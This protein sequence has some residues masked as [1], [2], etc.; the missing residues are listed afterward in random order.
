M[1]DFTSINQLMTTSAII[2][3]INLS[4]NLIKH[5]GE[6]SPYGRFVYSPHTVLYHT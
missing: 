5:A 1:T 4:K 3:T 6:A 2:K